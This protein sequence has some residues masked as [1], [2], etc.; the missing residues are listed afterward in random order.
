[1]DN[2]EVYIWLMNLQEKI[3]KQIE[4]FNFLSSKLY[5]DIYGRGTEFAC[6]DYARQSLDDLAK[7][8]FELKNLQSTLEYKT[9]LQYADIKEF[10]QL[11][12][13]KDVSKYLKK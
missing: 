9:K 7:L 2:D 13:N 5:E 4:S 1:M 10:L 8:K 11:L 3:K 6:S 12:G